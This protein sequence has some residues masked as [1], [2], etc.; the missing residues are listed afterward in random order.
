MMQ[1]SYNLVSFL[2]QSS[3][4]LI[5][6]KLYTAQNSYYFVDKIKCIS[7]SNCNK[8]S[9]DVKSLFTDVSIHGALEFLKE[10][11]LVYYCFTTEI[12]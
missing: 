3:S 11:L 1:T 7:P 12:V 10:T 6:N 9:L 8:L 5:H 2:S 4:Y